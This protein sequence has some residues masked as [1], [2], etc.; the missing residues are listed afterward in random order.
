MVSN[1][2]IVKIIYNIFII[3]NVNEENAKKMVE[4]RKKT[5]KLTSNLLKYLTVQILIIL[6]SGFFGMTIS[7]GVWLTRNFL[8]LIGSIPILLVNILNYVNSS[9]DYQKTELKIKLKKKIAILSFVLSF[10]AY[11]LLHFL[12]RELKFYYQELF[13][14]LFS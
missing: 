14:Q 4:S 1:L 10:F 3:N 2:L 9:Y 7:F 8:L 11:F 13:G 6:I 12:N 5:N